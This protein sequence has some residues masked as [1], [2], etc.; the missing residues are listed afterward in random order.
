MKI[1]MKFGLL[2]GSLV[3]LGATFAVAQKHTANHVGAAHE[4]ASNNLVQAVR[5]ATQQ[6]FNVNNATSAG[7]AAL[8][9]C[10]SGS[11]HG[12]MGIH[13]VNTSL[14]NGTINVTTPHA[15]IYEPQ[16][17]RSGLNRDQPPISSLQLALPQ[18]A[19]EPLR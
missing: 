12:A 3:F 19:A 5:N 11:D 7:Y 8:F 16:Q 14:L 1:N 17:N 9:G 18:P 10:V 15:L 13:Y 6:Y 4:S 2:A